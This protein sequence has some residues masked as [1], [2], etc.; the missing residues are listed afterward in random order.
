MGD[1]G[2]TEEPKRQD[3][4][5]QGSEE[6]HLWDEIKRYFLGIPTFVL[7]LL[8]LYVTVIGIVYSGS[9]YGKWT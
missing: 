4:D 3:N 1:S 7:T 2:M 9:L 6:N 8:Y 5:A